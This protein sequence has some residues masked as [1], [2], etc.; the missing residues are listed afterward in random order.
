MQRAHVEGVGA[1]ACG[2]VLP[3]RRNAPHLHAAAAGPAGTYRFLQHGTDRG[4]AVAVG[5]NSAPKA[6]L[7]EVADVFG[8]P[9]IDVE[10]DRRKER[11]GRGAEEDETPRWVVCRMVSFGHVVVRTTF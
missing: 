5:R 2:V 7:D 11:D 3:K 1:E 8:E 9:A 4:V 10:R 6:L